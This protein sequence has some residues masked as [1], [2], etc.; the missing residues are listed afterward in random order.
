[1]GKREDVKNMVRRGES[2]KCLAGCGLGCLVVILLI[3]GVSVFTF[4][5]FTSSTDLAPETAL[6]TENFSNYACIRLAPEDRG[7]IELINRLQKEQ[8]IKDKLEGGMQ[9]GRNPLA[10]FFGGKDGPREITDKELNKLLP[11]RVV[12]V[13]EC[14]GGEWRDGLIWIAA[15]RYLKPAGKFFGLVIREGAESGFDEV[16]R[17]DAYYSVKLKN[18]GP[19]IGVYGGNAVLSNEAAVLD[20]AVMALHKGTNQ[21]HETMLRLRDL[22]EKDALAYGVHDN[23]NGNLVVLIHTLMAVSGADEQMENMAEEEAMMLKTVGIPLFAEN[24]DNL[25]WGVRTETGDKL[26]AEVVFGCKAMEFCEQM[27]GLLMLQGEEIR[28]KL[29]PEVTMDRFDLVMKDGRLHLNLSF[30]GLIEYGIKEM[31][32][33]EV[34]AGDAG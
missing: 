7:L 12:L 2:G 34:E 1:M 15:A 22:V 10:G 16:R 26:H 6:M 14:L 24:L 4:W 32:K 25:C 21:R 23:R 17:T 8:F 20:D 13:N 3:V 28:K 31:R 18:G 30:S 19:W 11:V 33:S 5:W 27:K 9:D 29:P